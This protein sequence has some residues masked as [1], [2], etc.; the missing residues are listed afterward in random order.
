MK[1]KY[2]EEDI[3]SNPVNESSHQIDIKEGNIHFIS[4]LT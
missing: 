4:S 1:S 3:T 2:L